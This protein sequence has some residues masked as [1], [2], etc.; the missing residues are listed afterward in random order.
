MI[1][2]LRISLTIHAGAGAAEALAR[3]LQPDNIEIP[4]G[5]EIGVEALESSVE[6]VINCAPQKILTCRS[7]ADEI[8]SLADSVIKSLG[9]A[10]RSRAPR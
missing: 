9:A 2:G 10:E 8:L 6:V 3:A 1:E 4:E 7:T 5:V